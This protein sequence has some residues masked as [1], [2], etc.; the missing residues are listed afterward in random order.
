MV[1]AATLE[2][3][4]VQLGGLPSGKVEGWDIDYSADGRFLAASVDSHDVTELSTTVLVWDVAAPAEPILRF[5]SPMAWAVV[6]SPDG[7]LLYVGTHDPAALI[8]YDV[9]TGLQ[10][11]TVETPQ[12]ELGPANSSDPAD[13]LEVSP[14]GTTLAVQ[15]V[16]G[17][18]LLDADTLAELKRLTAHTDWVRTLEFSDDGA[19][20]ASGSNDGEVIV[21]D[22][23]TG[24][25]RE[26]LDAH[27]GAVWGLAFDA[28]RRH[29]V[30]GVDRPHVARLG[31]LR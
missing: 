24:N 17:V 21:W 19:M 28:R 27:T 23:A 8:V 30:L 14:D 6:L 18:V 15:D 4:P 31:S 9:A 1:D 3:E 12:M 16:E 26:L 2:D 5:R 25:Q 7:S 10:V 20:L 22:V 29:A 13:G 11:D